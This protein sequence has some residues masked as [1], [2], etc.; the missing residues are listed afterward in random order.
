M[1]VQKIVGPKEFWSKKCESKKLQVKKM[2]SPKTFLVQKNGFK[3]LWVQKIIPLWV[4]D[5]LGKKVLGQKRTGMARWG[6]AGKLEPGLLM[7]T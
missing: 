5:N 7:K 3:K 6:W 1:L 2:L 4:K